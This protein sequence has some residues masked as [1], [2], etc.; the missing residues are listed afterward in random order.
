MLTGMQSQQNES[1]QE[2]ATGQSYDVI[3]VGGGAAGLTAA[4]MLGRARRSVLVIDGGHPRNTPAEHM[5]GF[6]SRDGTP[7]LEFLE[8]TRAQLVKYD[9]TVIEAEVRTAERTPEGFRVIVA[10]GKEVASRRLLACSGISDQLPNVPGIQEAWGRGVVHCP[11]CH[12]WEI[13]D[14]RIGVLASVP[15]SIHQALLFRQWT[16]RLTLL[17]HTQAAPTAEQAE[18]LAARSIRI[19]SGEIVEVETLD[20]RVSG[21]R[22]VTGEHVAL[23]AIVVAPI[24]VPHADFLSSLGVRPQPHSS[25][26]GEHVPADETGQTTAPGVWAAGNLANP[27]LNVLGSANAGTIAAGAINADLIADDTAAAIR[28]THPA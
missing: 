2:Q 5:H 17:L 9:V 25:G 8:A 13:Q 10:S 1:S 6:P 12:G 11:Y 15:M 27:S 24:A 18:E 21:V 14:Q 22:L 28:D 23:D 4:L 7:P 26:L 20:G 16:D 19:V 3:V